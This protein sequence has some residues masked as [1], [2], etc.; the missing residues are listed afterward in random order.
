MQFKAPP[1]NAAM[2]RSALGSMFLTLSWMTACQVPEDLPGL[3]RC[4]DDPACPQDHR[5]IASRCVGLEPG[6]TPCATPALLTTSFDDPTWL[7]RTMSVQPQTIASIA[8]GTLSVGTAV[9]GEWGYVASHATYDLRNQAMI[10]ELSPLDERTTEISL[11]DASGSAVYMG[12]SQGELYV[13]SKGRTLVQIPY[14]P[15]QHRWWRISDDQG[16][17]R[18][19][20]SADA[21]TW[22]PLAQDHAALDASWTRFG[23][24]T[25]GGMRISEL[26]PGAEQDPRWCAAQ[27]WR[28]SFTDNLPLPESTFDGQACTAVARDGVLTFQLAAQEAWCTWRS[29]RPVDAREGTFSF[30][31]TPAAAPAATMFALVSPDG[32]GAIEI[33]A[34]NELTFRVYANHEEVFS[35]SAPSSRT[36]QHWRISLA[37]TAVRF[38]TSSDAVTW[39]VRGTAN[40]PTLDASALFILRDT[41]A[42]P[43]NTRASTA[44]FGELQ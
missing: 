22:A 6:L 15:T 13:D 7:A 17:Q 29:T 31:V 19:E 40:A 26:N 33:R 3:F 24:A 42:D 10:M 44:Q 43:S 30:A 36:S 28:E 12:T 35:A 21:M 32:S 11:H 14:S 9:A 2:D 5:C 16:T 27:S 25:A 20:T 39:E 38:E 4:A 18:W 34:S 23:V 37:G 41:Y 8:N 1:Y